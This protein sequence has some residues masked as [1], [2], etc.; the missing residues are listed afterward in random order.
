M[1]QTIRDYFNYHKFQFDNT[2]GLFCTVFSIS[3][4]Q[5]CLSFHW[6]YLIYPLWFLAYYGKRL[7]VIISYALFTMLNVQT[8]KLCIGSEL[9]VKL[10]LIVLAII[11][12]IFTRDMLFIYRYKMQHPD[13]LEKKYSTKFFVRNFILVFLIFTIFFV[14]ANYSEWLKN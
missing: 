4:Y 1:F 2:L 14:A 13:E 7:F 12:V 6:W 8:L 11:F 5:A 10:N 3:V 9:P